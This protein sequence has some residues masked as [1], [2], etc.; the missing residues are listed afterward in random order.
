MNALWA[1]PQIPGLSQLTNASGQTYRDFRKTLNTN[2]FKVQFGIITTF[3]SMLLVVALAFTATSSVVLFALALPLALIQHRILNVIHEG[4]HFLLSNNRNKND[5]FCNL[6]SGWFILCDVDQYRIT[7][8]EHHRNLGTEFDP[9]NAHMEKLD[10][11]W[12]ISVITGFATLRRLTTRAAHRKKIGSRADTKLRHLIV[13]IIG[14]LIHLQVLIAM[15]LWAS[16]PVLVF[17]ALTTFFL[18]PALGIVRNLLEHKYV[19]SVQPEIWYQILGREQPQNL[20]SSVTTRTFT[21]SALSKLYGSMGFTRHLIHHWDPAISFSNLE[22]VHN[23][24]LDTKLG[25]NLTM[26]DATF[27]RTFLH[28]W[29]R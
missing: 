26:V 12:L 7:H 27:T 28:L 18:T 2:F 15:F 13:P 23:F 4:A 19:E 24:L 10:L 29:Q 8:I 11:T 16:Y 3:V 25:A 22:E 1:P 9:E 14:V 20:V 5:L 17:W 6:F 21:H